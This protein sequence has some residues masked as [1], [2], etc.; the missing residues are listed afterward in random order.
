MRFTYKKFTKF[1]SIVDLMSKQIFLYKV[2][3][4]KKK[5]IYLYCNIYYYR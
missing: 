5:N 2:F 4:Q 3:W 1:L